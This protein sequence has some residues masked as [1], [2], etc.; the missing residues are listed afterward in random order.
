M[1]ST[2]PAATESEPSAQQQEQQQQ[3]QQQQA[4]IITVRCIRSFE[5]RAL[6][7]LVLHGVDLAHTSGG[8]L[9]ALV[10]QRIQTAPGFAPFR[11][12]AYDTIK[13]H[14]QA[15]GA[16]TNNPIIN[17]DHDDWVLDPARTLHEQGVKHETEL[18][19]YR[20]EDYNTYKAH[21]STVW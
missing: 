19:M 14:S 4:V 10:K 11:A 6:K 17:L 16:K 21:P 9:M 3:Q 2:E 8:D 15:F 1:S 20:L 18:S 13:I 7:S 5:H 12:I